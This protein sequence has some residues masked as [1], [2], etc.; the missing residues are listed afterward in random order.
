MEENAVL[1]V[2]SLALSALEVSKEDAA[3]SG[4]RDF[5]CAFDLPDDVV[6]GV[7]HRLSGFELCL[8]ACISKQWNRV[9]ADAW[10][11][12]LFQDF[13]SSQYE[14]VHVMDFKRLYKREWLW[15]NRHIAP[16]KIQNVGPVFCL[17]TCDTRVAAGLSH[18]NV[19]VYDIATLKMLHNLCEI[20]STHPLLV[21]CIAFISEDILA[22]GCFC[23][24]IVIWNTCTKII[25]TVLQ[26][27]AGSVNF[28]NVDGSI[29]ASGSEDTQVMLWDLMT[30]FCLGSMQ[31][32]TST[33]NCGKLSMKDSRAVTGG[34]DNRIIIWDTD[35]HQRVK[36][37]SD[38]EGALFCIGISNQIIASGAD[39]KTVRLHRLDTGDCVG[40]LTGHRGAVWDMDWVGFRLVT[41]SEDHLVKLWNTETMQCTRTLTGHKDAIWGVRLTPTGLATGCLDGTIRIWV[42][43]EPNI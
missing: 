9:S 27:H 5:S 16:R 28:I 15:R 23:A 13:G 31:G 19:H 6:L 26:G 24:D 21:M 17:A 32:H 25:D 36:T 20:N 34:A 12:I 22:L 3:D 7:L 41:V 43:V 33:V 18:G 30:G 10:K 8:A 42:F 11:H 39:D 14:Q 2:C 1:G 38:H 37:I 35:G 29:L 4:L 40:V